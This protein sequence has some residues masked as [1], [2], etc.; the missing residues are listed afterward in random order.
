M[1][2]IDRMLKLSLHPYFPTLFNS[3][4]LHDPGTNLRISATVALPAGE[5][6]ALRAVALSALGQ[7]AFGSLQAANQSLKTFKERWPMTEWYDW[8]MTADLSLGVLH[9][10]FARFFFGDLVFGMVVEFICWL[11]RWI[12]DDLLIL[13]I[14]RSD[15]VRVLLDAISRDCWHVAWL[16]CEEDYSSKRR[17][18]L[19]LSHV[20]IFPIFERIVGVST[21]NTVFF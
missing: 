5:A 17:F 15:F 20:E 1:N 4:V 21:M 2:F 10:T 6:T 3:H 11:F 14:F 16:G 18:D 19:K 7:D 8:Q 13:F 12:V 9:C